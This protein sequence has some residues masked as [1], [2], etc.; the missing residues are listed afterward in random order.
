MKATVY[1][2]Q[3]SLSL[4]VWY[5]PI[6]SLSL[7]EKPSYC[8]SSAVVEQ[9]ASNSDAVVK[10]EVAMQ[11]GR[12]LVRHAVREQEITR[13]SSMGFDIRDGHFHEHC[14]RL[15][16]GSQSDCPKIVNNMVKIH[17]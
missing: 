12:E 5:G 11:E 10:M 14:A 8:Y 9:A 7:R 15:C 2:Q 16:S 13:Y 6:I 1:K 17:I 3:I 4:R